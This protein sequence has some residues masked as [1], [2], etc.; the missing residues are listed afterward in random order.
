MQAEQ[1]YDNPLSGIL[2]AIFFILTICFI[3]FMVFAASRANL[4]KTS[5]M[6][7][8]QYINAN[9]GRGDFFAQAV[10][11]KT[12]EL[13]EFC[14]IDD[15]TTGVLISKRGRIIRGYTFTTK[16]YTEKNLLD[17]LSKKGLELINFVGGIIPKE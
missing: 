7:A 13:W 5:Y 11:P 10:N 16:K 14:K 2:G 17:F 12:G 6:T 3:L 1:S 8:V 9:C 15:S 4:D